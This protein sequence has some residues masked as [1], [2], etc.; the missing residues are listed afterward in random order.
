MARKGQR[1]EDII[2]HQYESQGWTVLTSGWPDFLCTKD[3]RIEAVE[4]KSVTDTIKPNQIRM[5]TLLAANGIKVVTRRV[6]PARLSHFLAD[7]PVMIA[8]RERSTA[9][10]GD[11]DGLGVS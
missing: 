8:Y 6:G 7:L 4:V 1:R 5:Q 9:P 2:R 10:L 3:G 11:F